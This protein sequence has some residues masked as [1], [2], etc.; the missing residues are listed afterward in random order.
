MAWL[1]ILHIAGLSLWCG[2]LLYLPALVASSAQAPGPDLAL[3]REPL[4]LARA[5]FNL[6]ATPAALFA[7]MTGTALF[8]L[9]GIIGV[10][11]ILKLSAV[12]ALVACH[13]LCGALILRRERRRDTRLALPCTVLGVASGALIA[14]ILWLVLAKPA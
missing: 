13:A 8:L 10:W 1:L 6:V 3:A 9:G 7:I 11:L 5:L 4:A 12:A 2:T 14:T